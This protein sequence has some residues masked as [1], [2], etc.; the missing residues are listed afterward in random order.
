MS[1]LDIKKNLKQSG[2]VKNAPRCMSIKFGGIELDDDTR[3]ELENVQAGTIFEVIDKP[4]LEGE[5]LQ[6]FEGAEQVSF[7]EVNREG[8]DLK[9]RVNAICDVN[10]GQYIAA[11]VE[12]GKVY[13][14]PTQG[15]RKDVITLESDHTGP[16]TCLSSAGGK[17]CAGSKDTSLTVWDVKTKEKLI[18][19][20]GHEKGLVACI[21]MPDGR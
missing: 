15:K 8:F 16:I 12:D 20:S 9:G 1:I 7:V 19:L 6:A 17:L 4:M 21:L 10:Q 18:K 5:K 11:A 3:L 13:L 2:M 14:I